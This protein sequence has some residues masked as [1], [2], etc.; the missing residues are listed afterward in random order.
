MAAVPE[1]KLNNMLAL[2]SELCGV[3]KKENILLKK[4]RQEECVAFIEKKDKLS[5]A[6]EESFAYFSQN[7]E[8]LAGLTEKQKG[9]LRKAA[10]TLSDLTNENARLL[11]I[12]LEA[13]SRLLDAIVQDVQEQRQNMPLYTREGNIES[14]NGNPAALSFNEVL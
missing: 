8:I 1:K 6:Y 13:T 2:M 7:K 4:Q 3:L 9:V 10:I 14:E 5:T 11:K 12:N